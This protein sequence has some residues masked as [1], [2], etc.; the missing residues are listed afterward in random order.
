MVICLERGANDLNMIELMPLPPYHLLLQIQNGLP[1]WCRLIQVVLE[2][3]PLNTCNNSVVGASPKEIIGACTF[4][5]CRFPFLSSSQKCQSTEGNLILF[6]LAKKFL[7]I[8]LI[9]LLQGF[10]IC[11]IQ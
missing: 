11:M 6:L 10:Y 9:T 7:R 5:K 3:R 8:L 1:F 4:V 2:K